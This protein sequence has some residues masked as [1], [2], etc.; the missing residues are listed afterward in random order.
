MMRSAGF[1][2]IERFDVTSDFRDTAQAWLEQRRKHADELIELL[3]EETHEEKVT[4]SEDTIA[5]IDDGL[6]R[7]YLYVARPR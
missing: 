5:A 7:R 2:G 3:G 4:D 1:V 6:I